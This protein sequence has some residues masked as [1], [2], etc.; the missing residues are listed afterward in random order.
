MPVPGERWEIEF[1]P[2]GEIEVEK[3]VSLGEI[4]GAESL[5]GLFARYEEQE[6]QTKEA[7]SASVA[8]PM[9]KVA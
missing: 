3:F 1:L 9:G 7:R 8:M 2:D 5:E 6:S 4:A